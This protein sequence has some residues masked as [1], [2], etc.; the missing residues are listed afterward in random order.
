MSVSYTKLL[1]FFRSKEWAV[2]T[3]FFGGS[4]WSP[5]SQP[6][7]LYYEMNSQNILW[8]VPCFT[9]Q[10]ESHE[11]QYENEYN[12]P[13]KFFILKYEIFIYDVGLYLPI[14]SEIVNYSYDFWENNELLMSVN[15]LHFHNRDG[16]KHFSKRKGWRKRERQK[17]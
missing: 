8:N 1:Y 14:C 7:S 4:F 10:K 3:T 9:Q 17:L 5:N 13:L 12:T 11:E 2:L 16:T 6:L 15:L